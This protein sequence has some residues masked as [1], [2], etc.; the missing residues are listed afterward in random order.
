M[1]KFSVFYSKKLHDTGLLLYD[2]HISEVITILNLIDEGECRGICIQQ[3][4]L[5][6][7]LGE[8]F[9][10]IIEELFSTSLT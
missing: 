1:T 4:N 7:S 2:S 5:L 3:K 9:F 10:V 6:Q 8:G